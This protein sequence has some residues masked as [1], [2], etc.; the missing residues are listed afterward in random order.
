MRFV[1]NFENLHFPSVSVV[2]MLTAALCYRYMPSFTH[3]PVK[4]E[5]SCNRKNRE[6]WLIAFI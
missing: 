2:V 5:E 4:L 1:T 6:K 3:T